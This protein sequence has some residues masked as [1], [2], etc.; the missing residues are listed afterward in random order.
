MRLI[1]T[2]IIIIVIII[3]RIII[4]TSTLEKVTALWVW[5]KLGFISRLILVDS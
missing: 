5:Y 4:I 2:Y 1:R 3:V